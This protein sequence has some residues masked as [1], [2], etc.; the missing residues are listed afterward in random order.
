MPG[1]YSLLIP[2]LVIAAVVVATLVPVLVVLEVTR[3]IAALRRR[4]RSPRP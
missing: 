4:C 3:L 1:V 2:T